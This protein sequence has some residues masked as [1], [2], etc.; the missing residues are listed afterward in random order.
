MEERRAEYY[1]YDEYETYVICP[2]CEDHNKHSGLL[3]PDDGDS[4]MCS[5]CNKHF[6]FGVSYQK[7]T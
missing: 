4:F 6:T 1:C 5:W 3:H 2:F 7:E